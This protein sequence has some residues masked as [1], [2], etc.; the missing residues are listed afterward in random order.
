MRKMRFSLISMV[1][2]ILLASCQSFRSTAPADAALQPTPTVASS[3]FSVVVTVYPIETITPALT[4][5]PEGIATF[6]PVLD[7]IVSQV[8]NDLNQ[9]TGVGLEK[10]NVLEVESVEWPDSSLGCGEPGAVYLPVITPGFRIILEADGH[11]YSY[12]T[13]ASTQFVL[14][15]KPQ[16]IKINPTP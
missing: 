10:I 5:Y 16:P 6:D 11:I 4:G 15:E 9:K 7:A 13:S 2:Y 14:C 12:H 8:K 1:A 3:I